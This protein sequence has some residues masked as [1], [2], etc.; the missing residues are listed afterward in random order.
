LKRIYLVSGII[1]VV[2][3]LGWLNG[4][5]LTES[6]ALPAVISLAEVDHNYVLLVFDEYNEETWTIRGFNSDGKLVAD[7][8]FGGETRYIIW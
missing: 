7:K 4:L 6:S 8:L 3:L 5:R 1:L 2:V